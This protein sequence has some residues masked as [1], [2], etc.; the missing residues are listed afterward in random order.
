M[1]L[2]NTIANLSYKWPNSLFIAAVDHST[3]FYFEVGATKGEKYTGYY[4]C[5]GVT[6]LFGLVWLIIFW[7][8]VNA[9]QS[10]P[11][12]QWHCSKTGPN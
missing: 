9:L 10:K 4:T 7:S 6:T 8:R 2:L 1:T 5:L 11:L 3:K 12:A